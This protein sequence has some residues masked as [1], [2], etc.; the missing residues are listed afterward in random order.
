MLRSSS[1][2]FIIRKIFFQVH[3]QWIQFLPK[4]NLVSFLFSTQSPCPYLGSGHLLEGEQFSP[5]WYLLASVVLFQPI[6]YTVSPAQI[7]ILFKSVCGSVI[8]LRIEPESFT[9]SHR[10]LI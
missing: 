3:S 5:N 2:S 1:S 8:A 4:T 10:A 7:T 6:P 9:T